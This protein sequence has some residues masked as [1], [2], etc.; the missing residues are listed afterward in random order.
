MKKNIY[1][2]YPPGYS[3]SYLSWSLYK[4]ERETSNQTIDDPLN[5]NDNH[6]FG[7]TGTS[8]L[9]TRVPTHCGIHHI[10]YWLI[11]HK[12]KTK[13][14]F[15]VNTFNKRTLLG[16]IEHILN[17]DE[18]PVIIHISAKSDLY[19]KF[20]VIQMVTKWPIYFK[21]RQQDIAFNL[22]FSENKSLDLRNKFIEH[23]DNLVGEF[24][25]KVNFEE[26]DI[27]L[28]SFK[29]NQSYNANWYRVRNTYNP[30][31]V[32]ETQFIDSTKIFSS[33][34]FCPKNYYNF[35]LED[36]I[37][38]NYINELEQ[39]II[40]TDS[41]DFNFEF[42][43]NFHKKY[44]ENQINLKF[45]VDF[46]KW[47]KTGILSTYLENSSPIVQAIIIREMLTILPSFYEYHN[48]NIKAINEEYNR[49]I[50]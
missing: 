46:T 8:H 3:G 44:L 27:V 37:S 25:H 30:H 33:I 29:N 4:S 14:I 43:K 9:H 32:N 7:G 22:N 42:V 20:A 38:E 50:A 18:D 48:L 12:P 19:K 45:L 26:N 28:D 39:L 31:E 23:Y 41:G 21:V 11:R 13:K 2:L 17:F 36:I 34:D 49:L 15:L 16:A 47:K 6:K 1:L 10:M 35:F 40:Q 5:L 24:P